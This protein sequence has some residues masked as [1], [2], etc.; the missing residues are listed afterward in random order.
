MRLRPAEE[1]DEFAPKEVYQIDSVGEQAAVSGKDRSRIDRRYV[2]SGRRR[3]DRRAIQAREWVRYDDK[4]AARLAPQGVDGGFDLYI[5][6]YERSD[7][8]DLE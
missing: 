5:A 2:V 1:R 6:A 4:A 3:Y 8:L 7:W